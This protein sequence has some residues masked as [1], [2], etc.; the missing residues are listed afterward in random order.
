MC[1]F[2]GSNY[3][4]LSGKIMQLHRSEARMMAGIAGFPSTAGAAP[5]RQVAKLCK[6]LKSSKVGVEI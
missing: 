2:K 5:S 3:P 4:P 6:F 1:L